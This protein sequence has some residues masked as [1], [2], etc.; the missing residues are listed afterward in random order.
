MGHV[1]VARLD[2]STG[3]VND[4]LHDTWT[5]ALVVIHDGQLVEQRYASGMTA[6]TPHLLMSVSKSIVGCVAGTL[7]GQGLLSPDHPVSAYVP[8]V[9]G[10][11]YDEATA[12][13]LLDMRTGVLFRETYTLPE[14]EVRVMERSMGWRPIQAGDPIGP[15]PT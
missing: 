5:D 7:V 14:A 12:R 11:G 6:R 10:S 13:H 9:A 3:T 8:E 4:V 2:G 15:T 1:E